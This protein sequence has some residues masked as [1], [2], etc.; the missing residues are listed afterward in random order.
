MKLFSTLRSARFLFV[1]A[2]VCFVQIISAAPSF[3][4][5]AFGDAANTGFCDTQ[6]DDQKGGW[7]DQ[8]GNDLHVLPSGKL[9]FSGVPFTILEEAVIP[10]KTCIVLGGP[11]R[12]YFPAKAIISV[13]EMSGKCLYLLHAAAW[14][15][16]AKE[17]KMTGVLFVEYANGSST[18]IHV[19][20]G[21]DVGDWASPDS[22]KNAARVW[23]AYNGNTQVSLFASR[24]SL[25]PLPVKS[26]RFESREST[27]MI[28][29]ASIGD[30]TA[31]MPIKPILTLTKQFVAPPP[32]D[33]PLQNTSNVPAP[34]NIIL[35]IGDG[36][37]QGALKLTSL[38]QHKAEGK[39]LMEQLPV[40]SFCT[41]RS[42]SSEVTDSAAAATAIAC[43][44]KTANSF[45]GITAD[46]QQQLTSF[47]EVAH[48]GGRAVGLITSDS[49]T[50]A[51]P[52]GFYAHEASRG[53]Y[54]GVAQDAAASGFDILIGNRNGT[55]WFLPKTDA[56]QRM[57]TR[58]VLSE[59][60]ASGYAV[61]TNVETFARAPQDKRIL[62]FV[63]AKAVLF[64]EQ[65]LGQLTDI[66]VARLAK[67]EKGFFLMVE[68]A[69]TDAGGHGNKPDSTVLGT[70]MVDWTVR[71]AVEFARARGDTLVL[72]TADH[73]TGGLTCGITNN[74][75]SK[76]VMNYST[77]SHTRAPVRLYAYGPGSDLFKGTVDNTD[78]A[79]NI[80]TFWKL[81]L[82]PPFP[83]SEK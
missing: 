12:P 83:F 61:V 10:G 2:N 15:P 30:E 1:A 18:E 69:L 26:V 29:A 76:L 70:L 66:A 75:P 37:G 77:T 62:G 52:A 60:T 3:T 78:I 73:E 31:L 67:N 58:N 22:Y 63:D 54:Q 8:G 71:S 16:P 49:I 42:A 20:F 32:F 9:T 34:K 57:D 14:C 38:Y 6:A 13:P 53:S 46:K 19:R 68:C 59:M 50:G 47:T 56:G 79:K 40:A 21:R 7:T 33:K 80:C 45:L 23:T 24:F 65:I 74:P 27:W 72:V 25:K 82:P 48:R 11:K 55:P 28:V 43:G 41:T 51:T 39:L 35:I 81:T 44:C 17:Q 4:P 64:T 5:L 36:M